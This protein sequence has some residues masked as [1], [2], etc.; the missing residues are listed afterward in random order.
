ML[1]F[2]FAGGGKLEPLMLGDRIPGLEELFRFIEGLALIFVFESAPFCLSGASTELTITSLL[3]CCSFCNRFLR[4]G[5]LFKNTS[6][7]YVA[8]LASAT[9][10]PPALR[11]F[12]R[13]R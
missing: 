13:I 9:D 11:C 5:I 10:S 8:F 6:G 2:A 12:L 4:L 7:L 1:V 3:F